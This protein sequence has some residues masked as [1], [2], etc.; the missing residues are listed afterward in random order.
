M[1]NLIKKYE[2]KK[3]D[4]FTIQTS[5]ISIL[6]NLIEINLL[7]LLIIG[8]NNTGKSTILKSIIKLYDK[9]DVMI[10]NTL[11]DQSINYSRTDLKIFCKS[12]STKKQKKLVI[13]DDID[14]INDQNQ[15]I[16]RNYI[17]KYN[18]KVNFLCTGKCRQ[19]IIESIQSRLMILKLDEITIDDLNKI[20]NFICKKENINISPEGKK[21]IVHNC[22]NSIQN[23]LTNLEKIK[24]LNI[25]NVDLETTISICTNMNYNN[26]KTYMDLC[27]KNDLCNSIKKIYSIY[28]SGYSV[29]D[30]LDNFFVFIKNNNFINDINKYKIIKI[31]CTYITNYYN[32][33]ENEMELVLFTNDLINLFN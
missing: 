14:F 16:L 2:P 5:I 13:L 33:H 9:E 28:D 15:Q 24:I 1:E 11:T 29:I 17:D 23:M 21:F 19:K 3:L 4:D 25:E 8:N 27:I 22:G 10:V 20:F 26:F 32:Y 18:D 7:S 6:K 30:I 12:T 31:I